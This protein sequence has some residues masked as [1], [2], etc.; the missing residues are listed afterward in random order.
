MLGKAKD[1][2]GS[3]SLSVEEITSCAQASLSQTLTQY[4]EILGQHMTI[5]GNKAFIP[6][7]QIAGALVPPNQ[8]EA[9]QAPPILLRQWLRR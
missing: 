9:P 2:D 1:L 3:G 6:S 8:T 7:F 5:G 4:P